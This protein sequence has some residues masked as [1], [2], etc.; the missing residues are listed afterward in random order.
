[1]RHRATIDHILEWKSS[2]YFM[3]PDSDWVDCTSVVFEHFKG[4][5]GSWRQAI[6]FWD[7]QTPS[8]QTLTGLCFELWFG[9][10]KLIHWSYIMDF[11]FYITL[12]RCY[13]CLNH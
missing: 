12:D 8:M 6:R 13:R 10:I 11:K 1:L 4:L 7:G 9:I 5:D 3:D 2:P